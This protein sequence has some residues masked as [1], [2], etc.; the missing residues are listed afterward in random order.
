LLAFMNSLGI[1]LAPM[2]VRIN[3]NEPR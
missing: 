3:E 2:M 1:F